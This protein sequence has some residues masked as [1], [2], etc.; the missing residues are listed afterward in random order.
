MKRVIYSE[1]LAVLTFCISCQCCFGADQITLQ[2]KQA[3]T[4]GEVA[5]HSQIALPVAAMYP[6]YTILRST[7]LADWQAVAGPINGSVGVSDELLRVAV[8]LA[9]ARAFYRVAAS[10]K[11][12]S[13]GNRAGD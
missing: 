9:G 2:F 12:A 1:V 13:D 3:V 10:V 4:Q 8:P 11:L 7:N 6:E 5:L